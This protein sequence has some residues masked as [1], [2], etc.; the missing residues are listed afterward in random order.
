MIENLEEKI[1]KPTP[2][3]ESEKTLEQ[4]TGWKYVVKNWAVDVTAGWLYWTPVMAT[5]ELA[6][7]MEPEEV[8]KS[9]AMSLL[10]HAVLGR[11]YGKYRQVMA[12]WYRADEN[13][14]ELR[15]AASDITAQLTLQIPIYSTMLFFSGASLREGLAALGTGLAVGF[16]AGRPFGYVQ[17]RWRKLWGT[18]QTF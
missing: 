7:G 11:V 16:F 9:R 18:Q 5:T 6:S 12:K 13:S 3:K 10:N 4:K 14:S 2:F 17:D 15:K 8:I 1:S